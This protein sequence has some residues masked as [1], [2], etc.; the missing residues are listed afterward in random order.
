[1]PGLSWLDTNA[2]VREVEP[3]CAGVAAIQCPSTGIVDYTRVTEVL[4]ADMVALGGSVHFN[5]NVRSITPGSPLQLGLQDGR[6]LEARHVIACAGLHS[7]RVAGTSREVHIL[8]V[9]GEYLKLKDVRTGRAVATKDA[10]GRA[11][12]GAADADRGLLPRPSQH[13]RSLV[14]GN[15]YPVPNP[16]VPFL[17][18]HF[19]PRPNGDLWLGPNAVPAFAREGYRHTD[20]SLYVPCLSFVLAVFVLVDSRALSPE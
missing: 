15:I 6:V 2:A 11:R 16:A 7:D 9:R 20:L 10:R 1:M 8:P 3:H 18:V 19:T 5:S 12:A 13:K 4:A 14:R 17:G